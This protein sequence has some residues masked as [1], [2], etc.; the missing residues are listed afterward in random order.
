MWLYLFEKLER[1]I[2][3]PLSVYLHLNHYY[4]YNKIVLF[5]IK[6][7]F[8]KILRNIFQYILTSNRIEQTF[9]KSTG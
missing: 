3:P 6:T 4:S 5:E 2:V 1:A 8:P 9:A 7:F